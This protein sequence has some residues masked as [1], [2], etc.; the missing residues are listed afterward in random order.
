M[1]LEALAV[2]AFAAILALFHASCSM[3][4]EQKAALA[5]NL[6]KDGKAALVGGLAT[7]S[8]AGAAAGAGSQVIRNHT[9]AKQPVAKV[10]P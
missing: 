8:W 5:S 7:G 4:Q 9:A 1:K 3:T 10:T 2:L 6:A